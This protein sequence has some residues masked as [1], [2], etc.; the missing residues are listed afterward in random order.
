MEEKK[1]LIIKLGAIGDVVMAMSVIDQIKAQG[2]CHITWVCGKS[3]HPLLKMC[4]GIDELVVLDH[5]KIIN[6]SFFGKFKELLFAWKRLAFRSFSEVISLHKDARYRLIPLFTRK[7]SHRYFRSKEA[8]P[9]SKNFHTIDYLKLSGVTYKQIVT[10]PFL[11]ETS[12]KKVNST[13]IL[14]PGGILGDREKMNRVWPLEFYVELASRLKKEGNEVVIVG[15]KSQKCLENCFIKV[16][17]ISKIG[18]TSLIDTLK[19][20]N[21]SRLL[22]THDGGVF[23][24]GRLAAC[25]RIGIF[26]PTNFINFSDQEDEKEIILTTQKKMSCMPCYNG[27]RYAQC[28]HKKCLTMVTSNDVIELM[29]KYS[30]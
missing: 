2:R 3:V 16:G 6:G 25:K 14:S 11:R 27:K 20:L 4:S 18:Q 26:G 10:R 17:V 22:I 5:E 7:L 15:D 30:I 21:Q 1:V 12:L 24:L 19:M 8:F 13:I 9:L 23:H 29:K 28:S